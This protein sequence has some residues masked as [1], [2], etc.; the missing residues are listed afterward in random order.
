MLLAGVKSGVLDPRDTKWIIKHLR[1]ISKT[2]AARILRRQPNN[3]HFFYV[4]TLFDAEEGGCTNYNDRPGM[5]RNFPWY[6]RAPD[7]DVVA[8]YPNCSYLE[9]LV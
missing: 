4:C 6:G 7:K 8:N 5:C 2:G 1:R 9:D 3:A